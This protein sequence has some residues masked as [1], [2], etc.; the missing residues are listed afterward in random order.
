MPSTQASIAAA[1]LLRCRRLARFDQRSP[2]G[3]SEVVDPSNGC[4]VFSAVY[5]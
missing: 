3:W 2:E 1:A 4:L 5:R